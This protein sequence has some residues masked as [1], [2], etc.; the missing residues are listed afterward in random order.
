MM[1]VLRFEEKLAIFDDHWSPK[2]IAQMNDHHFKLAKIEGDFVWHS[3]PDTDEAFIVINGHMQISLRDGSV[4]LSAG[5]MCV[6]PKGVEHKPSA[7]EEC[8][9]L[10][11]EPAATPNTGDAGGELTAEDAWI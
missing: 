7:A 10:L 2:I 11:V 8:H 5:E 4:E 6:V 3:H 9:V 1:K